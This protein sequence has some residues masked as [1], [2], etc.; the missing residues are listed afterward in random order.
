M[1]PHETGITVE[2]SKAHVAS[3]C[4]DPYLLKLNEIMDVLIV[5]LSD[6]MKYNVISIYLLY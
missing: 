4:T 6:F 5:E 3:L 2:S 1:H